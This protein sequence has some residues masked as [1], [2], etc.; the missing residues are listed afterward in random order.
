MQSNVYIIY[1][2]SR[3]KYYVGSSSD[4]LTERLRRHNSVHGGYTG[5]T[6]D[7]RLVYSEEWPETGSARKREMQI[8]KWK[9]RR[10]IE[11]LIAKAKSDS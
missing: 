4:L 7:W 5:H 2:P 11:A 1:S 3:D 6:G 9:S 8:K 10:M